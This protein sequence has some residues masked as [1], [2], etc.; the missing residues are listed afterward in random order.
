MLAFGAQR[1][2]DIASLDHARVQAFARAL[3]G[4]GIL[5]QLL[6]LRGVDTPEKAHDFLQPRLQHLSDPF[7]LTDM[8]AAVDR[9][10]RARV[11]GEKVF[12]AGDFDVD[13]ISATAIMVNGLRR[14]GIDD[15]SYSIP[16]RLT[17]G[18]G[19][20]P[21]HVEAARDAGATLIVTVDNGISAHEAA[22]RARE[23]AIDMI[24]TDH[25]ALDTTL[26]EAVAVINPKR[27]TPAHPAWSL[28]GA[29]VAF[30][31][32]TA[33]N[34]T[35]NDLDIVALGT[36]AD[37]MPL[38]G[39]NRALVALGLRHMARHQR[40]GLAKLAEAARFDLSQVSSQRIGFQLGPRLNAA[41][42][43][44]DGMVA[45]ELLMADC[46]I[47][48]TKMAGKLDE[49]NEKRRA[50]EREIFDDAR[51]ELEE[52]LTEDQRSIVIARP[53]WHAGVIGIVAA[54]IQGHFNRPVILL[55]VDDAGNV[56]GS[57]RS[58][59]GF[60]MF[61]ALA[62]CQHLLTRFGGHKAA[63][64]LSMNLSE[65]D[66]FKEAFEEQVRA[67]IGTEEVVE[68]LSIDAVAGFSQINA[69][70]LDG[71]SRLEPFGQANPEPLFCSMGVE[72]RP[73]EVR[74]L[75]DAHL[76]MTLRQGDRMLSAIGFGMAERFYTDDF[77]RCLDVAYAPQYNTWR[78]ETTIQLQLKDL[79]PAT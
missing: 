53:G 55:T 31:V 56:R 33:L 12:V 42:R 9:I 60:N 17:E 5:A 61:D 71:L 6:L 20:Q 51:S 2:W 73:E 68:T 45:L 8:D 40:T 15:V 64:G 13:G 1:K 24:I 75:K 18:Y 66:A 39:E 63:A 36:V 72:A 65:L 14:F 67:Q 62:A 7:L 10:T 26:P 23:L 50:I 37:V 16:L 32:A 35:P 52:T 21:C 48:A 47:A 46:P 79:R 74:I 78:G 25:H 19:I 11:R 58:G 28:C 3:N 30:K 43:L 59:P 22:H 44:D 4:P 34:G 41:G 38:T 77:P 70:L 69:E 29:A 27:E 49:A 76:K 54:R 57:A